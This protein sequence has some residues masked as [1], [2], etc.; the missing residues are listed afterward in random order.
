ILDGCHRTNDTAVTVHERG[1]LH[2]ADNVR[3]TPVANGF[4]FLLL[5]N[6]SK[7]SFEHVVSMPPI[8]HCRAHLSMPEDE[9]ELHKM[10]FKSASARTERAGLVR[11]LTP[12]VYLAHPLLTK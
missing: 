11:K 8:E 9:T 1:E 6:F 10:N 4:D 12:P 7:T 5:F 2:L 3:K